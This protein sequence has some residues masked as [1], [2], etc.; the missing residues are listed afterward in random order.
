MTKYTKYLSTPLFFPAALQC[1]ES[2]EEESSSLDSLLALITAFQHQFANIYK[3]LNKLIFPGPF[4]YPINSFEEEL[5]L[6]K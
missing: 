2:K 3:G 5:F 6:E 4:L 1:K